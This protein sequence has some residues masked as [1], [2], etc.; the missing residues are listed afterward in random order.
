MITLSRGNFAGAGVFLQE[1]LEEL[2]ETRI[3]EID[4]CDRSG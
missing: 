1:L 4:F 3:F 2:H